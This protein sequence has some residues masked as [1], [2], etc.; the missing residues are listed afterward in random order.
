MNKNIANI[1]FGVTGLI[2][3]ADLIFHFLSDS[4]LI[5][6]LII[7]GVAVLYYIIRSVVKEVLDERNERK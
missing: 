3:L 1:I 2:F 5:L 4:W 6:L 7:W